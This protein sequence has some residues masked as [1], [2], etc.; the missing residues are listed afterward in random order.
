MRIATL[1]TVTLALACGASASRSDRRASPRSATSCAGLVSTDS[2]VYDTT[3]VAEQPV[4]RSGPRPEY[5]MRERQ[6][7][8]QGRVL[9]AVIIEA[10]GSPNQESVR[11]LSSVDPALDREALRWVS[12]ASFWPACRDGRPVRVREAIPIDFRTFGLMRIGLP[13]KRL[14]LAG[15]LVLKEAVGSC[16]G[17]HGTVVRYSCAGR[18]VA[19]NLSPIR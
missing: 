6:H 5:P 2:T 15:A 4:V 18:R 11:V 14:K 8:I 19:R 13:N 17:G 1:L 10:D 12:G 3:Q 7:R 9:I 16:P